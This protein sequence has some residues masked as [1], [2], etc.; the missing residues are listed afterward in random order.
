MLNYPNHLQN[1]AFIQ[2][3]LP[4]YS[5]KLICIVGII[6]FECESIFLVYAFCLLKIAS[7]ILVKCPHKVCLTK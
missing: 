5:N 2:H 3:R 1:N 6:L 7:L 4:L